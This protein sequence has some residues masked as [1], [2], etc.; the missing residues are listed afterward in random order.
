MAE[1]TAKRWLSYERLSLVRGDQDLIG[2]ID[3]HNSNIREIETRGG[4]VESYRD[5]GGHRSGR[6]DTHRPDWRKVIARLPDPDV[7]GIIAT[8]QDRISRDV[9]DTAALIKLCERYGKHLIIPTE[10]VDTTRT[11]WT[12]EVKLVLHIKA[13]VAQ[14]YADETAK[15]LR[16]R[17]RQYHESGILWG[18]HPFGMQRIGKGLDTRFAP[19]SDAPIVETILTWYASSLSYETVCERANESGLKFRTRSGQPSRF[20]RETIRTIVGNVL[21]YVGYLPRIGWDAKNDRIALIGSGTYVERYARA[22]EARRVTCITPAI[23]DELANAVIER[24]YR[25][26]LSGR[27]AL[28]WTPLLTPIAYHCNKRLRADSQSGMHYYRTVGT[29]IWIDAD[30]ID[31][32]L[33]KRMSGIQFPMEARAIIMRDLEHRAGDQGRVHARARYDDAQ[34]RMDELVGLLLDKKIK[35]EI[36]DVRYAEL[37]RIQREA[38]NEMNRV[39]DADRAMSMLADLSG[40]LLEMTVEARRRNIHRIFERVD[41]DDHGEICA[42][43]LRS[44]ALAAF[45]NMDAVMAAN[46]AEGGQLA[47]LLQPDTLWFIHMVTT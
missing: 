24:R 18:K 30:I 43:R 10:G 1:T 33:M 12:P 2:V 15:K 17:V 40:A 21:F 39:T 28:G 45:G 36:Y 34:V 4:I 6:S 23:S 8:F 14:H 5:A 46:S 11:G 41:F 42:L 19:S 47:Q 26:Q 25:N 27:K 38:T 31:A 35:R 3:Q 29:G 37:E 16:K 22:G 20:T 7:A 32:N 13:S 44:W 9:G